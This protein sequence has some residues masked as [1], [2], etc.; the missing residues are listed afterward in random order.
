M[1]TTRTFKISKATVLMVYVLIIQKKAH[2]IFLSLLLFFY[3]IFLLTIGLIADP[4]WWTLET[5]PMGALVERTAG[6]H[7]SNGP[8]SRGHWDDIVRITQLIVEP[9][10]TVGDLPPLHKG[11]LSL[12][13]F[14]TSENHDGL[15]CA[16]VSRLFFFFY[17]L[18]LLCGAAVACL[19]V[20]MCRMLCYNIYLLDLKGFQKKTVIVQSSFFLGT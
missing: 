4:D 20:F 10:P 18:N 14:I 8:T 7:M 9:F 3:F 12:S 11:L 17:D 5:G 6:G 15:H 1:F 19:C 13:L 2:F 16:L